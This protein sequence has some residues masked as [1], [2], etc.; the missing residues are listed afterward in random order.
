MDPVVENR[1]LKASNASRILSVERIQSLWNG[2]GYIVRLTLEGG[3]YS[4]LICKHIKIPEAASHPKGFAT[5]FSRDRKVKSYEV[6][7]NWYKKF[8]SQ[9]NKDN[10]SQ[11]ALCIDSFSTEENE[12]FIL[13]EDLNSKGFPRVESSLSFDNAKV[14][15]SW[16]AA[17]HAKNLNEESPGLWEEGTYWHLS[18]RPEE[19]E[20]MDKSELKK[21]AHLIDE[22]LKRSRF[23]TL[24]HGDAKLANFCFSSD[25]R[26]VA[27]VDFQYVGTGC[28]V[29]DLAYFIGSVFDDDRCKQHEEEILSFYFERLEY[30]LT[31][32][33]IDFQ[34]LKNE[35]TELYY[36]AIADFERFLRGW[37]P[38]HWK[39]NSYTEIIVEKVIDIIKSDFI[40]SFERASSNAGKIQLQYL[41]KDLVV[42]TK[43]GGSEAS[44]IVT[45]VDYLSQAEIY[46]SL[47]EVAEKYA[48][49]ILSEE[50]ED[51]GSRFIRPYFLA[52][53]PLDGTYFYAK[54]KNGY[55]VSLSLISNLGEVILGSVYF[56]S[57]NRFVSEITDIKPKSSDKKFVAYLDP[58]IEDSDLYSR[59]KEKFDVRFEGGAVY[60]AISALMSENGVYFKLP[61]KKQ[62]GGAIWDFAAV[63]HI[64]SQMD[65]VF[66]GFG[67]QFLKYN[68]KDPYYHESGLLVCRKE[69][70]DEIK[71]LLK[72]LN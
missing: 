62:G 53:D 33:N 28:G 69:N 58:S 48:P 35:W 44:S 50:K 39:S 19:Y 24:V 66:E 71:R 4:S 13:L 14:V 6:E 27:A 68:C 56:P 1:I 22:R 41:E 36:F 21:F 30:F 31:K 55:A 10:N 38:G 2:Y 25:L 26:E 34:G 72:E 60:N 11:T 65:A 3:I 61:K 47:K 7:A 54:K 45:E 29:K 9:M 63:S 67:G 59:V 46:K 20:I 17:F 40:D 16:L 52:I 5:D 15:I 51:D 43:N 8:N 12:H 42:T 57:E 18:T 32:K 70:E 23:Q 37:S 49:G 64:A